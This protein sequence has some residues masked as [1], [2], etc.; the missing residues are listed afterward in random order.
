MYSC[1]KKKKKK[2]ILHVYHVHPEFLE[3]QAWANCASTDQMLQN[4]SSDQGHIICH[5]PYLP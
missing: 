1:Y 3:K 2:K 4:T 5:L